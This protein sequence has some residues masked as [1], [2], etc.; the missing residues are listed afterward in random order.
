MMAKVI[1]ELEGFPSYYRESL[2]KR[3]RKMID[4][5]EK[6]SKAAAAEMESLFADD[7]QP[8]T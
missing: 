8:E 4:R 5:F 2:D 3:R 7:P 6:D 1:P